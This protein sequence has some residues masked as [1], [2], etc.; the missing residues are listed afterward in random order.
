MSTRCSCMSSRPS[1][2][3]A[4][5]PIG[6]AP[7]M[8]ASVLI[9]SVM[10]RPLSARARSRLALRGAHHQ[11]VEHLAHLDLAR[12]AR[13]RLHVEGEVEHVFLHR[14]GLAGLLLPA[15]VDVDVTGRTRAGA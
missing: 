11:P 2:S 13:V 7:M 8:N 9:D 15:L 14:R 6:P 1:S 10:R 4:N 12:E 3:T 5:S